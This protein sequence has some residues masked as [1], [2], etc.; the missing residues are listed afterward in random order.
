MTRSRVAAVWAGLLIAAAVVFGA[1]LPASA[2]AVLVSSSPADGARLDAAPSEVVLTFD[3]RVGLVPGAALVLTGTGGRADSGAARLSADGRSLV[4]P[5]RTG[6]DDDVYT[7]TWRIVS[8]DSHVV[9]GSVRFG[10]G[11]DAAAAAGPP[12]ATWSGL[13]AVAAV[14]TGVL[15]AGLVLAVGVPVGAA[16]L[17]PARSRSRRVR[18]LAAAGTAAAAAAAFVGLLLRGPRAS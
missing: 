4:I 10:V 11:R 7:A 1:P 8:A 16:L 3:E 6:L 9:D 18:A 12:Q 13:D 15:Y 14:V 2:H 17:A 5:L